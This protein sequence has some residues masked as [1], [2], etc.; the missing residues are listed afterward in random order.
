VLIPEM[1]TG[2]LAML[3]RARCGIDPVSV[4]K[5]RGRPFRAD[6]LAAVIE[7]HA[8]KGEAA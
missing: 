2:Q 1:N 3:I 4:S 7:T 6:E 5:L 8:R